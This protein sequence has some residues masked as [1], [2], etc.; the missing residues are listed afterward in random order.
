MHRERN[1]EAIQTFAGKPLLA[2][3]AFLW[4]I[5][6]AVVKVFLMLPHV[7]HLQLR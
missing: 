6:E 7:L 3:P 5:K 2:R 1:R 4:D